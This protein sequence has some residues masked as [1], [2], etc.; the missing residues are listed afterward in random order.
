MAVP[1]KTGLLAG[2]LPPPLSRSGK[3]ARHRRPQPRILP[4]QEL[5]H[6]CRAPV[7]NSIYDFLQLHTVAPDLEHF[8]YTDSKSLLGRISTSLAGFY[9]SHGACLELEFD[10][11]ITIRNSIE[12]LDLRITRKHVKGHQDD[13][14]SQLQVI[15][16]PAQLNVI[17]D[18]LATHQLPNADR[19]MLRN[20]PINECLAQPLSIIETWL[21]IV[22]HAFEA[23]RQPDDDS[24]VD[25]PLFMQ[26]AGT[27]PDS[28]PG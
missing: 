20:K 1:Q 23:A 25:D 27:P 10:L 4:L 9:P 24:M 3:A 14:E 7:L 15:P 18:N 21:S 11:E 2:L 19:D 8:Q 16:W 28:P 13:A 26:A 5:W 6:A 12:Q 22:E 17:C